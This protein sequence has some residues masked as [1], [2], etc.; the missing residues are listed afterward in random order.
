MSKDSDILNLTDEQKIE[1]RNAIVETAKSCLNIPYDIE[2]GGKVAW[3]GRGKWTDLTK[4]PVSLDCSGL[5]A[6][7]VK[8]NGLKFPDG[9]L[10]QYNF[11]VATDKPRPGDFAFFADKK[12][13][14]K[15]DHVGIVYDDTY[16]IEARKLNPKASFPTGMVILRP[17][18]IWEKWENFV[19]Y[20]S[21]PKLI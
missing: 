18:S 20:R 19:G 12:D 3:T 14:T 5:A 10:A 7:C 8:K 21:H 1:I 4:P 2:P 9:A 15:V 11:T 16:M 17:R 6:G 13:I